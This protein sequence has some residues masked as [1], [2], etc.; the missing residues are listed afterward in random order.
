MNMRSPAA[1]AIVGIVLTLAACQG[2]TPQPS[3]AQPTG[4]QPSGAQPSES[5][6]AGSPVATFSGQLAPTRTLA[7][8]RSDVAATTL[9]STIIDAPDIDTAYT[10]TADALAR[11]GIRIETPEHVLVEPVAP[12]AATSMWPRQVLAAAIEGQNR[13]YVD[14][15]SAS[16]VGV[17]LSAMGWS[18]PAQSPSSGDGWV[19][20]LRAWLSDAQASPDDPTSFAPL[21]VAEMIRLGDGV[22]LADATTAEIHFGLLELL[23]LTAAFERGSTATAIAPAIYRPFA[24]GYARLTAAGPCDATLERYGMP[25]NDSLV[26]QAAPEWMKKKAVST[27]FDLASES[28]KNAIKAIK[29]FEKIWRA[30]AFY[31][32]SFVRVEAS[33]KRLHKPNEDDPEIHT[34]FTAKTGVDP[35]AFKEWVKDNGGPNGVR[36]LNDDTRCAEALGMPSLTDVGDV[37]DDIENWIVDWEVIEG[38][39]EHAELAVTCGSAPT[40]VCNKF[41]RFSTLGMKLRR[42]GSSVGEADLFVRIKE[43]QKSVHTPGAIER[44]VPVSVR[45]KIDASSMPSISPGNLT[46]PVGLI[47][48]GLETIAGLI[49]SSF[50]PSSKATVIVTYHEAV[51]WVLND[52]GGFVG[53]KCDGVGGEWLISRVVEQGFLLTTATYRFVIDEKTLAGTFKYELVQVVP[54]SGQTLLTQRAAGTASIKLG[55]DGAVTMTQ[56]ATTGTSVA[57]GFRA[58]FDLEQSAWSWVPA[59]AACG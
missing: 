13:R 51:G 11:A 36:E 1:A 50:K 29:F 16:D 48:P 28:V 8:M 32:Y 2:E 46:S 56:N 19:A 26:N 40:S 38:M 42:T 34:T 6:V 37:A 27:V 20:F 18:F 54:Q 53:T 30:A 59:G 35:D 15:I 55:S 23:V 21:F 10:A 44:E 43:E 47:G 57:S 4:A 41:D 49:Q 17:V 9:A 25:P 14:R 12:A 5:A 22:Q 52:A 7:G 31:F 33:D 45:A 39:P 3:G 24:D 58:D